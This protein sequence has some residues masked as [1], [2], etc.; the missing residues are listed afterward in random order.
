MTYDGM[1]VQTHTL[2]NSMNYNKY[3][4]IDTHIIKLNE[5]YYTSR[6]NTHITKLNE[7]HYT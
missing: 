5:L 3:D 2:S 4:Y 1:M 6:T 7:P